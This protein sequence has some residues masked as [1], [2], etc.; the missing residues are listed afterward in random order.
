MLCWRPKISILWDHELSGLNAGLNNKVGIC[1]RLEC[2]WFSVKLWLVRL[3]ELCKMITYNKSRSL[4]DSNWSS[5]QHIKQQ[6]WKCLH[7]EKTRRTRFIVHTRILFGLFFKCF[8]VTVTDLKVQP[9]IFEVVLS[10]TVVGGDIMIRWTSK[11]SQMSQDYIFCTS[12]LPSLNYRPNLANSKF[13]GKGYALIQ[14][15]FF[16]NDLNQYS[17]LNQTN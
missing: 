2:R 8:K 12:P 9:G 1:L 6:E 15:E 3:T 7:F 11:V 4:N 10:Q 14:Y 13:F 5:C 16:K 17:L